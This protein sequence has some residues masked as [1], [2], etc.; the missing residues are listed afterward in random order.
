MEILLF[1]A[2]ILLIVGAFFLGLFFWITPP[3][4]LLTA[5]AELVHVQKLGR[6][7]RKLGKFS[8]GGITPGYFCRYTYMYSVKGKTYRISGECSTHRTPLYK[9]AVVTF[10]KGFPRLALLSEKREDFVG[11]YKLLSLLSLGLAI[12]MFL[13]FFSYH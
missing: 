10:P 5:T 6:N 11:L 2:M 8:Y 1:L 12:F 9:K 4:H 3:E 13:L 7:R